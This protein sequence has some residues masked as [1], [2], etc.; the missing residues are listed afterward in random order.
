MAPFS[1]LTFHLIEVLNI[2]CNRFRRAGDK[3]IVDM[4]APAMNRYADV[5]PAPRFWEAFPE[6]RIRGVGRLGEERL[7]STLAEEI[8]TPGPGQIRALFVN[9]GNLAVCLPDQRKALEALASLELLVVS[10][11]FMSATAQLADYVLA[12]VMMYERSDVP[13]SVA[14]FPIMPTSWTQYTPALID[15]PAGADVVQDWYVYWAVAKRLGVPLEYEGVALDMQTPPSTDDLLEI[16]L[17]QAPI[18]LQELKDHL[19]ESPGG[20]MYDHPSAVVAPARPGAGAKFDVMP[21]DVAEEVRQLLGSAEMRAPGADDGFTHLLCSRRMNQVLNSGGTTLNATLKRAPY[22][23]AYMSP[24]DLAAM[25]LAAGD[26]VEIASVHGRVDAI[27]QPDSDVRRR[28]VSIAHAWGGLPGKPGPGVNI[29]AL[30]RC[31]TDVQAINAMPRMS[32][33]PVRVRKIAAGAEG[34]REAVE[35]VSD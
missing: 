9:G 35:A 18:S 21:E 20:R 31:D 19:D 14:A 26:R 22:N 4:I 11:P 29:N 32:A 24:D 33:V 27:V 17:R 8:L 23:P 10:D 16:R 30:T 15:P 7:T 5:I 1:N 25:D 12:P 6:S 34:M 3:T 2:I 13:L 28:V